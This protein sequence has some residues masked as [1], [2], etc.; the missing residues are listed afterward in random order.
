MRRGSGRGAGGR[1][2][3]DRLGGPKNRAVTPPSWAANRY[4]R[5]P[6]SAR[7][8]RLRH[9][10]SSAA[11]SRAPR[12]RMGTRSG[13][14]PVETTCAGRSGWRSSGGSPMA[15]AS[16]SRSS[17][18]APNT[19]SS[20]VIHAKPASG[21]PRQGSRPPRTTCVAGEVT[22]PSLTITNPV[23]SV[24]CPANGSSRSGVKMRIEYR[25]PPASVT[26]VDSEKPISSERLHRDVVDSRGPGTTQSW[27]PASGRSVNTS[28]IRNGISTIGQ[29]TGTRSGRP[30]YAERT[31]SEGPPTRYRDG[32]RAVAPF[33]VAVL[34]FGVSFGLLARAGGWG[35]VTPIVMSATTFAGSAQFAAASISG[36]AVRS[37]RRSRPRSC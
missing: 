11:R 32:A 35:W 34:G 4:A 19:G 37:P 23:P 27:L 9:G 15:R 8:P 2:L 36:T 14:S 25:S 30:R 29:P 7:R 3:A 22:R 13:G 21:R 18:S 1:I 17:N 26:N 12:S 10:R 24:G 28:T 6:R 5:R 33:G 20:C 31:M 16:N